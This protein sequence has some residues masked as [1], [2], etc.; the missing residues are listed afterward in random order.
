MPLGAPGSYT[1]DNGTVT[2]SGL[3]RMIPAGGSDHWLVLYDLQAGALV[4]RTF[5]VGIAAAGDVAVTGGPPAPTVSGPPIQGR[6]M[7][8]GDFWDL[9]V[10]PGVDNPGAAGV[11]AGTAG[12]EVLHLALTTSIAE[13]IL[14]SRLALKALGTMTT[15]CEYV[16]L[17]L[18]ADTNS[19][20]AYDTGDALLYGPAGF[21]PG[22]GIALFWPLN[23]KIQAAWTVT[24][25]VVADITADAPVGSTIGVTLEGAADIVATGCNTANTIL[26]GG[27]PVVGELMTVLEPLPGTVP[28]ETHRG[29]CGGHPASASPG[30]TAGLA[31]LFLAFALFVAS[32]KR[33]MAK[34]SV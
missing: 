5:R 34:S 32:M 17:I 7:T 4:G 27:V 31:M 20:G 25:F 14:V 16:S 19:H 8:V 9:E 10:A 6:Q 22:S 1:A 30:G 11:P 18:Y 3:S 21:I 33:R 26:A 24:W 15:P 13:S 12:K 2:I 29:G 28:S 23:E